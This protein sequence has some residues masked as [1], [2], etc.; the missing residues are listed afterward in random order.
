SANT[1]DTTTG[2]VVTIVQDKI[3]RYYVA[4][5]PNSAYQYIR[6][7]DHVSSLLGTG[8]QK[9]MKVYN[10]C[11]ETSDN[12]CFPAFATSADGSGLTA[13]I[14]DNG[15]GVTNADN[16]ISDNSSDYSEISL[17]T[18]AVAAEVNQTIYFNGP[19]EPG[20]ELKVRVQVGAPSLLDLNALGRCQVQTY[21]GDQLVDDYTLEEGLIAG[22]NVLNI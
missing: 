6:I 3:G 10:L 7:T 21:L 11:Y 16:A 13:G 20:D 22:L 2:G 19:S 15:A 8:V 9:S 14:L 5:T 12:T 18:A 1:F 17:G 4:I